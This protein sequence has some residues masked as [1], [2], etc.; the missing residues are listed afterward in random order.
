MSETVKGIP[1]DLLIAY[2][3]FTIL[4]TKY[5]FA[6]AGFMMAAEPTRYIGI[7]NVTE[8][9]HEL[10]NLLREYAAILDTTTTEGKLP[11][12]VFDKGNTN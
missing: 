1:D 12:R 9:G 4:A 2:Q 10:A 8:N 5:R 11:P 6:V 3:Q 7:G